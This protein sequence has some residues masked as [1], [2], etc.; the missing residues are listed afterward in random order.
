M[1]IHRFLLLLLA[2]AA[3]ARADEAEPPPRRDAAQSTRDGLLL[4]FTLSA[5]VGDARVVA[6]ALG[7][8]STA[9]YR[10]GL[11]GAVVE[12]QIVNRVAIRAGYEFTQGN[13]VTPNAFSAG[14]RVAL[15]RQERHYID[16]ALSA[17]YR[18]IG[19]TESNGL[20]ELGLLVGRRFGNLGLFANFTF[21]QG[22]S[23]ETHHG[24]VRLA[25][26]YNFTDRFALGFDTRGR[27]D[28]ASVVGPELEPE[29]DIDIIAGPMAT[30]SIG[31]I[32]FIG[33]VGGQVLTFEER[34]PAGGFAAQAG[35]GASF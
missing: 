26:L 27:F 34:K 30:Y 19:L 21:A 8:Y 35:L 15:L 29:V 32:S 22:F 17:A 33:Q 18:S 11:F 16:L 3:P 28:M 12:G 20:V 1:H 14:V 2:I 25:A 24:E 6:T 10:G 13:L 31:P 23:L 9:D 5:R 7:G 4:P